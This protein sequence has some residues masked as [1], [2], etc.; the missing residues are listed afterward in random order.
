M[1]RTCG[2][3]TG[4]GMMLMENLPHR[5]APIASKPITFTQANKQRLAEGLRP[6]FEDHA[7]R[8]PTIPLVREDLHGITK[9]DGAGGHVRYLGERTGKAG[10]VHPDRF[11]AAALGVNAAE[12]A[13]VYRVRRRP[14]D[15]HESRAMTPRRGARLMPGCLKHRAITR[16]ITDLPS[17]QPTPANAPGASR[18]GE[19][20]R[21][22]VRKHRRPTNRGRRRTVII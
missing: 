17:G 5:S 20:D 15:G 2:D 22:Q 11:W 4:L 3:E 19:S 9:V 1:R 12:E 6:K 18:D 7:C 10:T 13:P 14:R 21:Q 8:I 16:P